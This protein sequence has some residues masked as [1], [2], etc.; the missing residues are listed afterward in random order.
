[1]T[2]TQRRTGNAS[3][4]TRHR[5]GEPHRAPVPAQP[6]A[7]N[8]ETDRGL[9]PDEAGI[10]DQAGAVLAAG[11][12]REHTYGGGQRLDVRDFGAEWVLAGWFKDEPRWCL[13][14]YEHTGSL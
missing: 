3:H 5:P 8:R 11:A 10:P 14:A 9:A 2:L 6:T 13:A 12:A 7:Q 1:M 4:R